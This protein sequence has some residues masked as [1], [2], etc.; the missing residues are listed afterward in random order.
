V[1]IF[2]QLLSQAATLTEPPKA[3]WSQELGLR[4]EDELRQTLSQMSQGG[5][6]KHVGARRSC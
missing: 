2:Q 4:L 1:E 5:A 3:A 6:A